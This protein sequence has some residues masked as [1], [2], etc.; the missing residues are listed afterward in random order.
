MTRRILLRAGP[1]HRRAFPSADMQERGALLDLHEI[2]LLGEHRGRLEP[3]VFCGGDGEMKLAAAVG[4]RNDRP[5]ASD[6]HSRKS[7]DYEGRKE[8][9]VRGPPISSALG[10]FALFVSFVVISIRPVFGET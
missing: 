8:R 4:H 1:R 5:D 2:A 3:V 6:T 7:G 10:N 9:E